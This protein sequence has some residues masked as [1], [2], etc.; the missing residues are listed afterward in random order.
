MSAGQIIWGG[1]TSLILITMVQV[2]ELP[3]GSIAVQIIELIPTGNCAPFSVGCP[4]KL[5]EIVAEQLSLKFVGLNS[6][7]ATV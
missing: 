2:L 1:W 7:P 3:E 6:F 5:F 4:L